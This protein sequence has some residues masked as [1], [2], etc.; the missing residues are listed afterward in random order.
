MQEEAQL[1]EFV[2]V[3]QNLRKIHSAIQ[4]KAANSLSA[5]EECTQNVK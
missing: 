2:R 5:V 3:R 1:M 4:S